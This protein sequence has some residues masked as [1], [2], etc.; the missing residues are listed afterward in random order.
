MGEHSTDDAVCGG[1]SGSHPSINAD[2]TFSASRGIAFHACAAITKQPAH[3]YSPFESWLQGKLSRVVSPA[4]T[5]LRNH[6]WKTNESAG[7]NYLS[8][9]VGQRPAVAI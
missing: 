3:P 8:F 4:E 9:E 1:N 6:F 7:F 5:L 2:V